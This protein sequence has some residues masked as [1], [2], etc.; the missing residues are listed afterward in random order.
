MTPT[1]ALLQ[2]QTALADHLKVPVLLVAE[3]EVPL[4]QEAPWVELEPEEI[5]QKCVGTI[6]TD[7]EDP[8]TGKVDR[9]HFWQWR[10]ELTMRSVGTDL[11]YSAIQWLRT[12]EGK[13][14]IG[15]ES[16]VVLS[17]PTKSA[18]ELADKWLESDEA[19]LVLWGIDV[20]IEQIDY[21]ASTA[22]SLTT[23]E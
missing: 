5:E 19:T 16:L 13:Q 9:Y 7:R 17:G 1:E 10:L 18:Y 23:A 12:E 8:Q 3:R 20:T 21:V 14:S 6:T 11:C 22:F 15:Y 2:L 4:P